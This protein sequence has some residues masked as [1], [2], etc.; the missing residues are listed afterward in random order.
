MPNET[1]KSPAVANQNL[2]SNVASDKSPANGASSIHP[3]TGDIATVRAE[4][5]MIPFA[6]RVNIIWIM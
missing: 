1:K 2:N 5:R 3:P 6:A 4:P